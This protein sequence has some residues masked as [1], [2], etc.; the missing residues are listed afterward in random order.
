MTNASPFSAVR[1]LP[2]PVWSL[3]HAIHRLR[4]CP[5]AVSRN[6]SVQNACVRVVRK[7]RWKKS[8]SSVAA[9]VTGAASTG[10]VAVFHNVWCKRSIE[11][12]RSAKFPNV[13]IS[14]SVAA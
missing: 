5:F 14:S 13:Q 9:H 2:E 4:A 11:I 8:L 12:D 6:T 1:V 7:Q 3:C 10:S